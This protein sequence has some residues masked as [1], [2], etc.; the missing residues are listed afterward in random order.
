M[1]IDPKVFIKSLEK[2]PLEKLYK[3]KEN[4]LSEIEKCENRLDSNKENLAKA[5]ASSETIDNEEIIDDETY[6]KFYKEYV[7][8]IDTLINTKKNQANGEIYCYLKVLVDLP[9]IYQAYYY[10]TDDYSIEEDDKVVV[11]F[12]GKETEGTV[13]EV[14]YY[15]KDEVP[16]PIERTKYIKK[17]IQ[18]ELDLVEIEEMINKSDVGQILYIAAT[19][20][21]KGEYTKA[22]EYYRI[23]MA[24][25][26][27]DAICS[28]G[29]CFFYGRG[30]KK[31]YTIA[32]YY[33]SIAKK[34]GSINAT[35]K[36]G[37]MYMHGFGVKEDEGIALGLYI[38]AYEDA[39]RERKE[40]ISDPFSYPDICFRMGYC[41]YEGI[42]GYINK[43]KAL[44]LFLEAEKYFKIRIA[45]GDNFSSDILEITEDYI[46][47][48]KEELNKK[49]N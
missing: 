2:Y 9:E 10:L 29:Y 49:E 37:D 14:D 7:K 31:D 18:D 19:S 45:E 34:Y 43:N 17:K 25:G 27:I 3:E 11:D 33:F 16:F 21:E 15:K 20:Y 26:S 35:Y 4:L 44:E 5:I 8:E 12:N 22:V 13:V 39:L 30:V 47:Q 23:A 24:L 32:R 28:L 40:S 48:I 41:Y 6:C 36:L 38:K 46:T 1:I 42:G